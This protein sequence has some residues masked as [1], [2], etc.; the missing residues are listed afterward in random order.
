ML[1]NTGGVPEFCLVFVI[2]LIH[3]TIEI[4]RWLASSAG[5]LIFLNWEFKSH[6]TKW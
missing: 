1:S 6:V 3:K 5:I 4:Y 2:M